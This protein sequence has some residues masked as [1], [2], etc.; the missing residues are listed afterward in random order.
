MESGGVIVP[1]HEMALKEELAEL[2]RQALTHP[3]AHGI[4]SG[5][6]RWVIGDRQGG[7]GALV[8]QLVISAGVAFAVALY[9]ADE[10]LSN[11]RYA[12]WILFGA[13][14]G[15]DVL[16]GLTLIAAG[17]RKD[18]LGTVRAVRDSITGGG[19]SR[20]KDDGEG[21]RT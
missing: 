1:S 6:I 17:F 19:A 5:F 7:M 20:V 3:L 16:V 8:W 21:G 11:N 15:R 13:F 9:L 2:A 12:F 18:P 4:G 10:G 14:V